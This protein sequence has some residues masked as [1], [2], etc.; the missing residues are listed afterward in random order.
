VKI[1]REGAKSAKQRGKDVE[2]TEKLDA[3]E[4]VLPPQL[5]RGRFNAPDALIA[6]LNLT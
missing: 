5:R 4:A 1:H 6:S 3:A 2:P